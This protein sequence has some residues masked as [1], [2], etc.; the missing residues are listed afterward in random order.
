MLTEPS[1]CFYVCGVIA[2]ACEFVC[3]S[4]PYDLHCVPLA[5]MFHWLEEETTSHLLE[6]KKIPIPETTKAS[7]RTHMLLS[8]FD[9]YLY[10]VLP[11]SIFGT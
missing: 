6:R 7:D 2:P 5:H 1:C 8:S 10:P 9:H 11:S 4:S 3:E